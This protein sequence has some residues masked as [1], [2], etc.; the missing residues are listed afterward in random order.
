MVREKVGKKG[1][2]REKTTHHEVIEK[3]R[4]Y[5]QMI[6]FEIRNLTYSPI[7]GPEGN[8]E[9]LIHLRKREEGPAAEGVI[10]PDSVVER[11]FAEL[12]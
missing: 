7:K 5:V 4:F 3:I 11:A 10:D 8:I 2:V 9:Y 1:V 6:G 12:M